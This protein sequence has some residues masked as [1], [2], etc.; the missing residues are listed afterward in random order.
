[1]THDELKAAVDAIIKIACDN[2]VAHSREDDLHR[3]LIKQF[4]PEWVKAEIERL[5]AAE[6]ERWCA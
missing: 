1:M 6:F 5:S 3:E 2:E 4:C